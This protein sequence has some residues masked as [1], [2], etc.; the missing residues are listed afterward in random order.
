MGWSC[1][2]VRLLL[3]NHVSSSSFLTN[4]LTRL[5]F[6]V[7]NFITKVR[8]K[9]YKN[10]INVLRYLAHIIKTTETAGW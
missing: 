9:L 3:A 1:L 4:I 5:N 8:Y 2:D 6:L 7:K 10:T